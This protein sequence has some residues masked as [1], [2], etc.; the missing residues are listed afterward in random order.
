M[1]WKVFR[2]S[3]TFFHFTIHFPLSINSIIPAKR[4]H[5]FN[6]PLGQPINQPHT[7]QPPTINNP[8]NITHTNS[9]IQTTNKTTNTPRHDPV[10]APD[11]KPHH[12]DAQK[13]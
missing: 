11:Q 13:T 2:S 12:T 4:G 1:S 7:I 6:R 10:T 9:N 8:I 3:F 5:P